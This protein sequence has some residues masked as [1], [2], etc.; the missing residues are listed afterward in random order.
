MPNLDKARELL[1][2]AK[3]ALAAAGDNAKKGAVIVGKGAVIAGKY[4]LIVG[5][6]GGK[7]GIFLAKALKVPWLV[8]WGAGYF[9]TRKKNIA[10]AEKKWNIDFADL[11]SL[12]PKD[13]DT[14]KAE[15]P[16]WVLDA[17]Y[18]KATWLN[19]VLEKLWPG[20]DTVRASSGSH[21]IGSKL[22]A[23]LRAV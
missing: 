10:A 17:D 20:V 2:K 18:E 19:T 23:P 21:P 5:R 15:L 6:E 12:T 14:L 1:E 11:E 22:C 7:K 4:G 13:I 9:L 16:R 8:C 3:P